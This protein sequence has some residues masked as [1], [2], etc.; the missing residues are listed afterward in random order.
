MLLCLLPVLAA[1]QQSQM[2]GPYEL[3][4][5]VVNSTFL[6]PRVAASYGITRGR[7]R[8][9]LNLAVREHLPDGTTAARAMQLQGSARDLMQRLTVLEF[10]EIRESGAIYYIAQFKFLDREWH[11]FDI[12]FLPDGAARS[13]NFRHKHQLY[14]DP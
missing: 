14:S 2:F 6:E 12:D 1:A 8:A 11:N 13:Y 4:Y 7:D 3:H 9:F 5:S 10:Q